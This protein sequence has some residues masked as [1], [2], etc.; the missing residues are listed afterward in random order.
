MKKLVFACLAC[1]LALSCNRF[2]SVETPIAGTKNLV[3]YTAENT[4]LVGIKAAG[5]ET[6]LTAPLYVKAEAKYGYLIAQLGRQKADDPVKW[7]L[8]DT[9]GQSVTGQ[10]YDRVSYAPAYF[11]LENAAGKYYLKNGEK[12]AFGPYQDFYLHGER[13]FFAKDGKWGIGPLSAEWEK[14][15]VLEQADG[16]DFRYVVKV[17]GKKQWKIHDSSGKFLK[18]TTAAKVAQM[19]KNAKAKKYADK[20]WGNESTYGLTVANV[21][22]Y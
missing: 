13:V 7:A 11:M 14:I 1:L 4:S 18:N 2:K 3:T 16:K 9:E 19:E 6:T 21:K 20:K 10:T 8:L 17:P 22:A 5:A 12:S 15:I